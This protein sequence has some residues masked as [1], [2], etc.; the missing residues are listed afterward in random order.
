MSRAHSAPNG[1]HYQTTGRVQSQPQLGNNYINNNQDEGNH[2]DPSQ[3]EVPQQLD[4]NG[5]PI[6]NGEDD[7]SNG[8]SV[9]PGQEEDDF[10]CPNN[11]IFADVASGCQSYHVC[12]T[13]AQVQEKFQCPLGTLFND[14][15]LTC[16]FAHNV[17]CGGKK[18]QQP[19]ASSS[20]LPR[21]SQ[22]YPQQQQPRPSQMVPT[23]S[24]Y[25]RTSTYQPPV[26][27]QSKPSQQARW[28]QPQ[29]PPSAS[30][31]PLQPAS[32]PRTLQI[33][34]SQY[35]RHQQQMGSSLAQA[36]NSYPVNQPV[37]SSTT[38]ENYQDDG[39]SNNNNSAKDDS[40]DSSERPVPLIPAVLPPR[41][42]QQ[43]RPQ[44]NQS[45]QHQPQVTAQILPYNAPPK[46]QPQI[47]NQQVAGPAY[48]PR[49]N[50]QN[51]EVN[52]YRQQQSLPR[53][54]PQYLQQASRQQN[55]TDFSQ[56]GSW[57]GASASVPV[58]ASKDEQQPKRQAASYQST[59]AT[60][61][62]VSAANSQN[63]KEETLNLVINH[64]APAPTRPSDH[65]QQY[66]N[67]I[68]QPEQQQLVASS[69]SN[70]KQSHYFASDY[71]KNNSN[72]N[73]DNK[74]QQILRTQQQ[75]VVASN[76]QQQHHHQ[77]L[78]P[79]SLP[80][81]HHNH[82]KQHERV[83]EMSN[84]AAPNVGPQ[85]SSA[86][87]HRDR[88]GSSDGETSYNNLQQ[89][90]QVA[91]QRVQIPGN[92]GESGRERA[93]LR[94]NGNTGHSNNNQL[95][96]SQPKSVHVSGEDTTAVDTGE[97]PQVFVA[98]QQLQ[99]HQNQLGAT[100]ITDNHRPAIVDLTNDKRGLANGIGA[101]A[102]NDG[103]LLIVRHSSGSNPLEVHNTNANANYN[104]HNNR[105]QPI[106]RRSQPPPPPSS[107]SSGS[108][109][110]GVTSASASGAAASAAG[111]AFAVD[112]QA[113]RPD[114]PVDAQLFP[115]V[116]SILLSQSSRPTVSH[117]APGNSGGSRSYGA[118]SHSSRV[119]S[120]LAP[121]EPP[122]PTHTHKNVDRDLS[123]GPEM[124]REL[125]L[126]ASSSS[127]QNSLVTAAAATPS[128]S[129]VSSPSTSS[130]STKQTSAATSASKNS[131]STTT[132]NQAT[133]ASATTT[134]TS[135]R[136]KASADKLAAVSKKQL[137]AK[138]QTQRNKPKQKDQVAS[139]QTVTTQSTSTPSNSTATNSTNAS[140][141]KRVIKRL[142]PAAQP[143]TQRRSP[144]ST[145]T[146]T[147]TNTTATSSPTSQAADISATAS[148]SGDNGRA[149][150]AES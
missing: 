72:I 25:P 134:P 36:V 7:G 104:N 92:G 136:Q 129:V 93:A 59:T 139:Q 38:T 76:E 115:N 49:P 56:A 24:G 127:N 80:T 13:G 10:E 135:K 5:N 77:S 73:N 62:I 144:T 79:A 112:P 22:Q 132:V 111:R 140:I 102:L 84:G 86:T 131:P 2:L 91:I 75:Q 28:S 141:A 137:A 31:Y 88:V 78:P 48:N 17:Q 33:G 18:P 54:M 51:H 103:L 41:S 117:R 148:T 118:S 32:G 64:V 63:P 50:Q 97:Q 113:V 125:Q 120:P 21:A 6:N 110:N 29:P 121:M 71:N 109:S 4:Q 138:Q 52:G 119:S 67:Q 96:A 43:A 26:T 74:K 15:I 70:K 82:Q 107:S 35:S 46:P 16:D 61:P 85:Y 23:T 1:R 27:T 87:S 116:Q 81:H 37:A 147:T 95:Q 45:Q 14:I 3:G 53:P 40:D 66:K 68:T 39:N 42:T 130:T 146:T 9:G 55:P 108:S 90:Q 98:R 57:D 20:P 145:S 69:N 106:V 128:S 8:G 11:G 150:R 47:Q 133:T 44:Y 114:S 105:H 142:K 60:N 100:T 83:Q 123:S 143:P 89:Q 124:G 99:H 94:Y 58:F 34:R 30:Q 19:V 122:K 12:Q 126:I 101:D 149:T 65:Q